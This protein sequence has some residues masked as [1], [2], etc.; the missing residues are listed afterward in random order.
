MKKRFSLLIG[1]AAAVLFLAVGMVIRI[2][3][4]P[5]SIFLTNGSTRALDLELPFSARIDEEAAEV[6]KFSGTSLEDVGYY[7]KN[8][9]LVLATENSGKTSI[10]LDLFGLIPV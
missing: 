3:E 6:V 7:D 9:P 8:E 4:I 5:N 1:T 2:A 10:S